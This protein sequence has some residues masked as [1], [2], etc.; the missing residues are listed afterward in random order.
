MPI[1]LTARDSVWYVSSRDPA[2]DA[3]DP[4]FTKKA[5]D[6]LAYPRRHRVPV[7]H[8]LVAVEYLLRGLTRAQDQFIAGLPESKRDY[9]RVA[10]GL[11]G[12]RG[13]L[14]GDGSEASLDTRKEEHGDRVTNECLDALWTSRG[15]ALLFDELAFVIQ[16]LSHP[17]PLDS[18]VSA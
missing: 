1:R 16:R 11:T 7:R 12:L 18:P 17:D 8:G 4:S 10:Y 6:A 5:V 2:A 15:A 14:N 9:E 13:L 3:E